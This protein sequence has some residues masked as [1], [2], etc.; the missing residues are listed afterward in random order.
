MKTGIELIAEERQEQIE[1]HGRSIESDI[2]NNPNEQLSEAAGWLCY[3]EQGCADLDDVIE[4][5]CPDGWDQALWTKMCRKPFEERLIIAGALIAA[6]IDR[7]QNIKHPT[8][9]GKD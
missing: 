5:H 1:K 4:D 3:N 8:T 6:E 7:L 9:H 2:E